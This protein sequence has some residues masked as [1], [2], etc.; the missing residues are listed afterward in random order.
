M[1]R[2]TRWA[3]LAPALLLLAAVAL[4]GVTSAASFPIPTER[5]PS[6]RDPVPPDPL[7]PAPVGI[8]VEP[9]AAPLLPLSPVAALALEVPAIGIAQGGSPL[10]F[11]SPFIP[12]EDRPQS[13]FAGVQ[14]VS[15]YGY[16]G[17]PTMGI[18]GAYDAD[19][20]ARE[21][22]KLAAEYDALNGDRGVRPALHLIVGVAHMTPGDDGL[23]LTRMGDDL[24]NEYVEAARKHGILLFLDIQIGWSDAAA[25][26]QGFEAALREPFVHIALDPEF[27]TKRKND[28]PGIVIGNVDHNEIN[29]VQR[30]LAGLVRDYD[31]PP[32]VLIVH[33]FREDMLITPEDY[34]QYPEV[35]IAIDM[36]GFGGQAAKLSNY[37]RYALSAYS[38]RPGI[39]LFY[40]WDEPLMTPAEIQALPA[41][42]DFIIY[43]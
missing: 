15:F 41:P 16:P 10:V 28:V 19:E 30:Y 25:E 29:A 37:D 27:A 33:Q 5:A 39:K 21:V 13:A 24:V 43:Q 3:L 4:P 20:A 32:K 6:L 35:E 17:F 1:P 40:D 11:P 7:D 9:P 23:Y 14:I 38:E 34:T 12:A 8:P 42:P 2:R 26:V 36:D 18:L 31:L 22:A